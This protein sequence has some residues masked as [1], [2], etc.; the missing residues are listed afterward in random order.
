MEFCKMAHFHSTAPEKC[1][2]NPFIIA[3]TSRFLVTDYV[4]KQIWWTTL[5]TTSEQTSL[6]NSLQPRET[7]LRKSNSHTACAKG[8]DSSPERNYGYATLMS[9]N[10]SETSAWWDSSENLTGW[11]A[12]C[13]LRGKFEGQSVRRKC[14][15]NGHVEYK[16][17]VSTYHIVLLESWL[18]RQWNSLVG[19]FRGLVVACPCDESCL[20]SVVQYEH[21]FRE[22]LSSHVCCLQLGLGFLGGWWTNPVGLVPHQISESNS[23]QD[24]K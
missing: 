19:Y 14:M 6:G 20:F 21:S 9:P 15:R 18:D 23:G 7:D 5:R 2:M 22:I 8:L 17:K 1:P 13:D 16:P 10:E 3:H 11:P 4:N 24:M 12:A